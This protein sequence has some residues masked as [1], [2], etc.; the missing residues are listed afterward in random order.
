[1]PTRTPLGDLKGRLHE[2]GLGAEALGFRLGCYRNPRKAAGRVSALSQGASLKSQ[3]AL[4]RLP[5][6]LGVAPEV[7]DVAVE[8][9]RD[10]LAH[11][12]RHADENRRR[13][14]EEEERASES[15]F[16]PHAV[17]QTGTTIPSQIT[18]CG[19]TGGA[20]RWLIIRFNLSRPP[21]TF[22]QQ[23]IDAL[24][25]MVSP[26]GGSRSSVGPLGS[27]STTLP[28]RLCGATS[29]ETLLRSFRRHSASVRC[30]CHSAVS[31]SSLA[32]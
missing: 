17:I 12:E 19:L 5:E 1:M 31:G 18:I 3:A 28:T 6:A 2:L 9:T 25:S 11:M 14:L 24:P 7:V 20:E 26:A 15:S 10:L 21:V 16:K 30:S 8:D 32:S 27:S 29:T 13:I 23:A 4:R 22:I